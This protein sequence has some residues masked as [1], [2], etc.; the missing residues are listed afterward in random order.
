MEI[1][2]D[3]EGYKGHYQISS[4]G[5][6]R[7]VDRKIKKFNNIEKKITDFC[8]K[9][10]LL[11]PKTRKDGYKIIYLSKDNNKK[12]LYIHH[13]VAFA[14]I[15]KRPKDHHICH[16]D[17]NKS[18]NNLSNLRYGTRSDNANDTLLHGTCYFKKGENNPSSKLKDD[19]I[20]YIWKNKGIKTQNKLSLELGV[21]RQ[22]IS[23]I[24][25][26]KNWKHLKG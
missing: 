24:Y 21:C 2:S 23:S 5:N 4:F 17:G 12:E 9:G 10:K 8:I 22:A 16:N 18:N 11:K 13:L 14:F 25:N 3:I 26:Q 6:I 1:W 7:S 20:K 19:D 15:G